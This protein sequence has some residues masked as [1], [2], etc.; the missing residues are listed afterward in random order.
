MVP[1]SGDDDLFIDTAELDYQIQYH[2]R[3]FSFSANEVLPT[4]TVTL[5]RS[6][7]DRLLP[8]FGGIPTRLEELA[9]VFSF[10]DK[11]VAHLGVDLGVCPAL[12]RKHLALVVVPF[13]IERRKKDES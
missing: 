4:M 2:L 12:H 13:G 6:S 3:P 8:I 7:I 5:F 9:F 1:I 11:R 10:L